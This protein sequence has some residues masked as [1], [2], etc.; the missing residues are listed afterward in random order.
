MRFNIYL[1]GESKMWLFQNQRIKMVYNLYL[2]LLIIL[3]PLSFVRGELNPRVISP[4]SIGTVWTETFDSYENGSKIMGQGGWFT[5]AAFPDWDAEVVSS[6]AR[7]TPNSLLIQENSDVVHWFTGIT[8][9]LMNMSVWQ[10]VPEN[11][12]GESYFILLSLYNGEY[13]YWATQL[14]IDS[15]LH[16][17]VSEKEEQT[18]PL[19]TNQWVNIIVIIDLVADT[20]DIYYNGALLSEKSWR[21]GYSPGGPRNFGAINLYANHATAI[22][23]DDFTINVEQLPQ[24]PQPALNITSFKAGRSFV[25]TLCNCGAVEATNVT[26]SIQLDGNFIFKGYYANGTIPVMAPEYEFNL[27]IKNYRGIGRFI[28]D[29]LVTCDQNNSLHI[30]YHGFMFLGWTFVQP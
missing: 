15:S 21:N 25:P 8:T 4:Y 10:Y 22:Y 26:W 24:P 6:N 13:S 11:F 28:A 1:T 12:S 17:I 2:V 30:Q 23:Y 16:A 14:R 19:I 5:W 3:L 20:Q 9:G 18:L 27:E 29:V 7:S